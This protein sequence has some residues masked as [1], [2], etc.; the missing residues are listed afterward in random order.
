MSFRGLVVGVSGLKSQS[1]KMEVIGNNLANIG[2]TGFKK[3]Q[4]AFHELYNEVLT[5]ASAGDGANIGGTNPATIGN[6]VGVSSITNVFSQGAREQTARTLDFMVDGDD[7][8]VVKSGVQGELMLTRNGSFQL[9]GDLYLTD[10]FGSK[11]QGF[12]VD[13]ATQKVDQT[14]GNI[15]LSN[16]SIPPNATTQVNLESNIDSSVTETIAGL[17]TNAFELFSAGENFGSMSISSGGA[18][19]N[20]SSYGSGYYQDSVRYSDSAASL[21]SGLTTVTLS[22]TPSNLVEGFSVGDTVTLLQGT[23][24][25]QRTISAIDSGTRE[26]TLSAAT[27][28]SFSS[29]TLTVTNLSDGSSAR[30]SSGSSTLHNDLVRSQIA[31]VDDDG[32][33]IA[34]FYRVAGPSADYTRSTATQVNGTEITVGTGEFTNMQE[35]KEGL[36]LALR[37]TQL[38]NYSSSSDLE[39]SLDKFGKISFG[40]SGLVQEFRLVMN[41]DNTEMLD[42]FDGIAISDGASTA[43]TQARVN[44]DG[45]IINAGTLGSLGARSTNSSKQWFATSGLEAYGYD[46]NNQSTEYGEFAGLRLDGGADGNSFGVV[47]LSLVNALGTTVTQEF[48]M[49]P[50]DADTNQ[51]EFTTM[52]EL[53]TLI[54]STLRS[55][56]FSSTAE[57]GSLVSDT[58]AAVNIINGRMSVSTNNGSFNNLR[59]RA[60]NDYAPADVGIARSDEM[61]FGT[62]LGELST[63]IYGKS[64]ISN[65][66]IEADVRSNTQVF[67]SQGNEHTITS[68]FVRD[69][70]SGLN[71]IEWKYK[72]GLNPNINTFA[73]QDP[74]DD[75]IY[76]ETFNSL[77]D[78]AAV[79]GVLAF[80]IDSG[81]VLGSNAAGS[82]ARYDS[83]AN[84]TFTAQSNSLEADESS[85]TLDFTKM[86]SYNGDHTV[87]GINVDGHAMGNL[88]RITTESNTGN[89]NGVYTN[90][91]VRTLA[92]VGLMSIANPEGL[93]KMGTSYFMQT[94]NSSSGGNPKG[95]DQIYAV[96]A[97]ANSS[98]DSVTSK[99]HGNSLEASN[100]DLTE[101]LTEMITTQR[102]YSASGRIITTTDDMIQEALNLKR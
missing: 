73:S 97:N 80:D 94:T 32:N 64:G 62:V 38:T 77:Q 90:G 55:E 46:A 39:V 13:P 86:T 36:E 101:E 58:T 100:V 4:V 30:G 40:G 102:S 89:I 3:S 31:M 2:T 19:G 54:Q 34:S 85:I 70:S 88:M 43:T 83:S 6:G 26:I 33:L 87:V 44:A 84:V 35:L 18:T 53:A 93:Q 45:K 15:Q 82:D 72:M 60:L 91:K 69:R 7:F 8:F 24:Q 27:P 59:I 61:N 96:G 71:N 56:N 75:S 66:F 21:D 23:D 20:R 99:I 41:A 51:N 9:D 63:G 12:N 16:G 25:V 10:A 92:K 11:I 49:V 47:E 74:D 67:D 79:R 1:Q 68:Y 95:T 42:R 65:R 22:A 29:G 57:D 81:Q 14:A 17:D 37:D 98:G 5:S 48:K 50:R 78:T 76:A 52:G 28:T